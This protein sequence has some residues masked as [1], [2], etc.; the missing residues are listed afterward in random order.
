MS[1]NDNPVS[2]AAAQLFA[3]RLRALEFI[4]ISTTT[5][6]FVLTIGLVTTGRAEEANPVAASLLDTTGWTI[7]GILALGVIAAVFTWY[8]RISDEYP[9]KAI[10]GASSVAALGVMDVAA[11]LALISRVSLPE[12]LYLSK[13][14]PPV[15]VVLFFA[16]LA[17]NRGT[18]SRKLSYIELETLRD[19]H[20]DSARAVVFSFILVLSVVTPWVAFTAVSTETASAETVSDSLYSG[21]GSNHLAMTDGTNAYVWYNDGSNTGKIR[22]ITPDGTADWTYTTPDGSEISNLFDMEY[23]PSTDDII[24]NY[25]DSTSPDGNDFFTVSVDVET[26]TQNWKYRTDEGGTN[27]LAVNPDTGRVLVDVGY[28]L[29]ILDSS[30]NFIKNEYQRDYHDPEYSPD[31]EDLFITNNY[32]GHHWKI[33]N[34]DYANKTNFGDGIASFTVFSDTVIMSDRNNGRTVARDR[35]TLNKKWEDPARFGVVRHPN[36]DNAYRTESGN[37]VQIDKDDGTHTTLFTSDLAKVK[38]GPS[39]DGMISFWA[40]NSSGIFITTTEQPDP[41]AGGGV[42][43]RVT[44]QSGAPISNATVVGYASSKPTISQSRNQLDSLSNPLPEAFREQRDSGFSL[45]GSGG[46]WQNANGRYVGV[47][48]TSDIAADPW[49]DSADLSEPM[50]RSVPVNKDVALVVGDPSEN[51]I[52]AGT[53]EYNR[54]IPG[55]TVSGTVVVETLSAGGDVVSRT[56]VETSEQSGGGLL[57]PSSMPYATMK[58]EPGVYRIKAKDSS[59]SYLIMAGSPTAI[60]DQYVNDINGSLTDYSQN[61]RDALSSGGLSRVTATT[62]SAGK[63]SFDVPSGTNV[64]HVQAYKSSTLSQVENI[65]PQN[66]TTEKI[67]DAYDVDTSATDPTELQSQLEKLPEGS[68]YMP[69]RAYRVTPPDQNVTVRMV[70]LSFPPMGNIST[71]QDRQKQLLDQLRNGS[72]QDLLSDR[73]EELNRDEMEEV[74]DRLDRLRDRNG[75]LDEKY[76]E[77]LE[78]TQLSD[79]T[80]NIEINQTSDE[81]LRTR[82]KTLQQ[83]IRGLRD[84]IESEPPAVDM[85]S[86]SANGRFTFGTPLERE[87]VTVLAHYSNGTTMPVPA[88]YISVDRSVANTVGAG[89]TTVEV[90]DF[91]LSE[92]DPNAVE[93]EV[94]VANDEGFG[95]SR[96]SVKNP[97]FSG[98][99]PTIDSV[100]V[101][102]LEPGPSDTVQVDVTP[103]DDSSFQSVT[104]ATVYG[105]SGSTVATIDEAN[106]TDGTTFNFSTTG[107]GRYWIESTVRGVDGGE[108]TVPFSISAGDVDKQRPPGIR[109]KSGPLGTYAVVGDGFDSGAVR[110]T[111]AG[112]VE[113]T[114]VVSQDADIPSRVHIYLSALEASRDSSV[115]VRLTRGQNRESIN[116]HVYVTVHGQSLTENALV[117]RG[118]EQPLT[119]DAS[120]QYGRVS[121]P[122]NG[123]VIETY[124]EANGEVSVRTINDPTRVDRVFHWFRV[125]TAGIDLPVIAIVPTARMTGL[126]SPGGAVLEAVV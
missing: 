54:Q 40:K 106:V 49:V 35:D 12:S 89:S 80:A 14:G 57:D 1:R 78:D 60:I 11:N 104:G 117:Y 67:R 23:S 27:G 98:D 88:E 79:P 99:L 10:Y 36:D 4:S 16:I 48:S 55:Q 38:P 85:G 17:W 31:G 39:Q 29:D 50:W 22:K 20:G 70:E 69:S 103:S 61:I 102:S 24:L 124:T 30:G 105:P 32:N 59:F 86:E 63:F 5:L 114:G 34:E 41:T 44:T 6:A 93:F 113:V 90:N 115:S 75:R 81:E 77:L 125:R 92:Q 65:D 68:V 53:N 120:T 74:Y 26:G 87:D 64:V 71:L 122:A 52:L 107:K 21:S 109:A 13:Y 37:L 123:T 47:Y 58:F 83:T 118:E 43:G 19:E 119:R 100:T 82:L 66:V 110:T 9:R 7:V 101:S 97:T 18:L 111:A 46:A 15:L 2:R 112:D 116:E 94:L 42:S 45:L 28:S 126:P 56:T 25:W 51:S 76:R 72:F 108:Y 121:M 91:P 33:E 84:T 95:S 3:D 73:V 96:Q 8:Q 62:D